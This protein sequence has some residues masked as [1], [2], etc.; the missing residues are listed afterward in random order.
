M[1]PGLLLFFAAL[2]LLLL[3]AAAGARQA[4]RRPLQLLL[5]PAAPAAPVSSLVLLPLSHYAGVFEVDL[6]VGRSAVKAVFDTG[7]ENL[8][9][10]GAECVRSSQCSAAGGHYDEPP[11]RATGKKTTVQYGTQTDHVR[12]YS[13]DVT[14]RVVRP[15]TLQRVAAQE[16]CRM[17]GLDDKPDEEVVVPAMAVGVVRQRSGVSNLNVLGFCQA[18]D[19]GGLRTLLG[20]A[21]VF[22]LLVHQRR[23]WLALGGPP[24]LAQCPRVRRIPL[25]RP[26]AG[27]L[28]YYVVSVAAVAVWR[29]QGRRREERRCRHLPRWV[30]IDTGSNMLSVS[31]P[32]LRELRKHG[33]GATSLR[34]HLELTLGAGA[35]TVKMDYAYRDYAMGGELLV[36][37][38]LPFDRDDVMLLGTLFMRGRYME[39]DLRRRTL[40]VAQLQGTTPCP[41]GGCPAPVVRTQRPG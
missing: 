16:G 33:L 37:D 32:L 36:R 13:D 31:A 35:E 3:L 24:P 9:V 39:F 15:H 38:N 34:T 14:L 5:R 7:S 18:A 22:A 1:Q 2:A 29:G 28:G 4:R 12:W 27:M 21:P 23:G 30:I 19:G 25:V 8:I 6:L 41:E 20:A 26:P 11:E 10:A 40:G 17:E